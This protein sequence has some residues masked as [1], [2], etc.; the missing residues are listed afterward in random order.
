MGKNNL[1]S[2]FII[3]LVLVATIFIVFCGCQPTIPE[4]GEVKITSTPLT[5]VVVNN[6]Y[7]YLVQASGSSEI[8]FNLSEN[9]SG[10]NINSS[11]GQISWIPQEIGDFQVTV[12][13]SNEESSATQ[14]FTIHVTAKELPQRVVML[15]LFVAP[16]C[17]NCPKA[18]DYAEDLVDEYGLDKVVVLEEYGWDRDEYIGWET[19]E[20]KKRYQDYADALGVTRHT[21]DLY[22]N[23]LNQVVHANKLSFTNYRN[24]LITELAKP[25]SVAIEASYNLVN[26]IFTVNGSMENVSS[27]DLYKL[28]I[29][30][31]LYEN[32]VYLGS[33]SATVNHVVRSILYSPQIAQLAASKKHT[34]SLTSEILTNIKNENQVHAVVFVQKNRTDFPSNISAQEI[35]QAQYIN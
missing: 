20:T 22:V 5:S 26:G 24:A 19:P 33:V 16:T 23:G 27:E 18:K 12:I 30:A 11:T 29:G 28:S 13:A 3:P 34:F 31:M 7:N 14:S 9:P 8:A 1:V 2:V 25:A 17:P 21:P 32:N 4:P 6:E 15:E 35:L 10:M